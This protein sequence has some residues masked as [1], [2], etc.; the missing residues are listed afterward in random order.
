MDS[1]IWTPLRKGRYGIVVQRFEPSELNSA[2]TLSAEEKNRILPLELSDK[3]F[4]FEQCGL[5]YRGCVFSYEASHITQQRCGIFPAGFILLQGKKR[6]LSGPKLEALRDEEGENLVA[7][8]E[9]KRLLSVK[10]QVSRSFSDLQS[11]S[12]N[13]KDQTPVFV[14][15][16]FVPHETTSGAK[17]PLVDEISYTLREWNES[18]RSFLQKQDYTSFRVV[19]EHIQ[20]LFKWRKMI[21]M[22]TGTGIHSLE[23]LRRDIML[24][25]LFGNLHQALEYY[26][27]HDTITMCIADECKLSIPSMYKQHLKL[28]RV[29]EGLASQELMSL[30]TYCPET[31]EA[32][33]EADNRLFQVFFEFKASMASICKPGEFADMRFS[34]YSSQENKFIT[35]EYSVE[36]DENGF[37]RDQKKLGRQ[38]TIFTDIFPKEVPHLFL[39]CRIIR[40]SPQPLGKSA[41]EGHTRYPYGWGIMKI[42]ESTRK[43]KTL[44]MPI[45]QSTG[46]STFSD[47]PELAVHNGDLSGKARFNN[48]VISLSCH[49]ISGD[50]D[51][52]EKAE[53]TTNQ[54]A[55]TFRLNSTEVL[56]L[57]D[58]RNSLTVTIIAGE[59]Q[60]S[61]KS[62][63]KCVEVCAQILGISGEL[64]R[65]CIYPS[66]TQP[67][68]SSYRTAT[69]QYSASVRWFETF[70][71]ELPLEKFHTWNI[72]FTLRYVGQAEKSDTPFAFGFMPL[73]GQ[74]KIVL[75]DKVHSLNLYKYDPQLFKSALYLR[76]PPF[77]EMG[78]TAASESFGDLKTSLLKDT[79]QV[80]TQ[81]YSSTITQNSALY[82][83]LGWRDYLTSD[84]KH[85]VSL[86]NAIPLIGEFE[87]IKF[88]VAIL[89]SL[90]SILSHPR[91]KSGV[92]DSPLFSSMVYVLNLITDRRF[93]TFLPTLQAYITDHIFGTSISK[94]LS[95]ALCSKLTE[96]SSTESSRLIRDT[97]KIWEYIMDII[98]HSWSIDDKSKSKGDLQDEVEVI[99]RVILELFHKR[100]PTYIFGSQVIAMQRFSFV[101]EKCI[102][103]YNDEGFIKLLG[104]CFNQ[105]EDLQDKL[106]SVA[107]HLMKNMALIIFK[108][109][110]RLRTPYIKLLT[111]WLGRNFEF[112][113]FPTNSTFSKTITSNAISLISLLIEN[114]HNFINAGGDE[115]R[116]LNLD[117]AS[118][119]PNVILS[120]NCTTHNDREKSIDHQDGSTFT[121]LPSILGGSNS[122]VNLL[123]EQNTLLNQNSTSIQDGDTTSGLI[124]IL[125]LMSESEINDYFLQY[126]EA[127]GEPS[128]VVLLSDLLRALE[129]ILERKVFPRS[130][131]NINM[132]VLKVA[133]KTV[134]VIVEF[135][136]KHLSCG[137]SDEKIW[138]CCFSFLMKILS[139][140]DLQVEMFQPQKLYVAHQIK[141]DFRDEASRFLLSTWSAAN[142]ETLYRTNSVELGQLLGS[143]LILCMVGHK[144]TR[145]AGLAILIDIMNLESELHANLNRIQVTW[146]DTLEKIIVSEESM[147]QEHPRK[148]L[149]ELEHFVAIKGNQAT[150]SL[151]PQMIR[152]FTEFVELLFDLKSLPDGEEYA[153][154]RVLKT[155]KLLNF[156]LMIDRTHI[157]IKYVHQLADFHAKR[158]RKVEAAFA[159][160]LHADLLD[161]SCEET[162]DRITDPSFPE[163]SSF[164]RKRNLYLKII[165]LFD[166]GKAW[167]IAIPM[168]KELATMYEFITCEYNRLAIILELQAS[169]FRN[170]I[171]KERYTCEYFRV[172]YFGKG[173]PASKRNK[174]LIHRGYE[175][176]K[177]SSFCERMQKKHPAA[178]I[179][180]S[181]EPPSDSILNS[182]LQYLQI[183]TVSPEPSPDHPILSSR[184][185]IPEFVRSYY[186]FNN[187]NK[188]S[189]LRPIKIPGKEPTTSVDIWVEKTILVTEI[190]F[191]SVLGCSE[192]ILTDRKQ[193]SPIENALLTMERKNKELVSLEKKFGAFTSG[194]K[195]NC[196]PLSMALSGACDAPVNGGLPMYRQAFLSL[197][198]PNESPDH[199]AH[200]SQLR[201]CIR[202]QARKHDPLILK[203]TE[204]ALSLGSNHFST[205]WRSW[206]ISL[207]V[208][209]TA[210]RY[211][212]WM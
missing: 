46:D 184:K 107:Y 26:V 13:P 119:I 81:L 92:F 146:I 209:E 11:P 200:V 99:I 47:I 30:I 141:L 76:L 144:G 188:F 185:N 49:V 43:D 177:I 117:L 180:N 4:V 60:P 83:L 114:Q 195:V 31:L 138:S 44:T 91:N 19:R 175:L 174:Q 1:Y 190:S 187:V 132:C 50:P 54:V 61:R 169:F 140:E 135:S 170:I 109:Y 112:L 160:K 39:V 115:A 29:K 21:I 147:K 17:E 133:F 38:R 66:A 12:A 15:P 41:I 32:E 178:L 145:K 67:A 35:E 205:H 8:N 155:L 33:L 59:F 86:L 156:F 189:F 2:A 134:K 14:L 162:L 102:H 53:K 95:K 85:V 75:S 6:P 202:E 130:W 122:S 74:L 23:K 97:L 90:F 143:L 192:V 100:E 93:K 79:L 71:L 98:I 154:D 84:D 163:Q 123:T 120:L 167:E 171:K 210:T 191:P 56:R 186:E 139:H 193:L 34:C 7:S 158:D 153:D 55:S 149:Q 45:Y 87:L 110:P 111:K 40:N 198:S 196:N 166:E 72:L 94:K 121:L 101:L 201:Q 80:R 204:P 136:L 113:M 28:T 127:S 150:Q 105:F 70:R 164:E 51:E 22:D 106:L 52:R 77:S 172:G 148:F 57:F 27:V 181:N 128:S 78:G 36:L 124:G 3:V 173:F 182:N 212:C 89:D 68:A 9:K 207:A 152:T 199:T 131:L 69:F 63:G 129:S 194:D 179:L 5:W 165:S 64:I 104:Y 58:N 203:L 10:Q 88:Q 118:L 208:H 25:T 168:C 211:Y 126:F 197:E 176:E 125:N 37:F 42:D 108:N 157:Y 183:T 206:K 62:S 151:A 159:L 16:C 137:S 142:M 18:A 73:T 20:L 48:D 24:K 116:G 103:V 65:D 161:W 82:Q 96:V